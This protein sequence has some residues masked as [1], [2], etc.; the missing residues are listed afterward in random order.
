MRTLHCGNMANIGYMIT[1]TLRDFGQ[2][3]FLLMEKNPPPGSDPINYDLSLD[4]KY[5]DWIIFYDKKKSS[6]K[7]DVIT[8]MRD[9]QFDLLHAH[10]EM[11]IFAYISRRPFLSH[12]QGSDLREMAFSNSLRGILL[13]RAYR[14]SKAMIFAS[15]GPIP[16]LLKLKLKKTLFLPLVHNTSF[17]KPHSIESKFNNKFVVFHPANLEWRLKGNQIF[18]KGFSEFVKKYPN[19]LLIIVDRGIDSQKTH[20]LINS[21]AIN[22]NIM[23]VKGP[24]NSNQLLYYYNLSDV[25][26]DD[27][28]ID[29]IGAIS[30]ES[31][32]C[33]KPLITYFNVDGYRELYG[34]SPPILNASTISEISSQLE[35]LLDEKIRIDIGKKSRDWVIR[36]Y[37]PSIF[38]QRLKIIYDSIISGKPIEEIR[39]LIS[40]V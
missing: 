22:K 7:R 14:K 32:S 29:D 8:T 20:E 9:K 21:L 23:Y 5:P 34:D 10:V 36:Q 11:P 37:S 24:L 2:D 4:G 25:V 16:S 17:F 40:E 3:Q 35:F 31:L 18:I 26:A 28:I 38:S 39:H 6:W 33:A 13:R 15:P 27:F 12:P 19:S 1:K 30:R